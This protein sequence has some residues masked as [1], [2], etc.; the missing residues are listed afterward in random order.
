M[1]VSVESGEGLERKLTIQVP[2][3]TV[4]KEVD[5]RLNSMRS[6][7]KI[8]GFRP[9]KVPLSVVKKQYGPSVIQE[10][11]GEVM[12]NTLRDAV[13]QES[14]NPAGNP[15]IEPTSMEPGKPLEFIATFEVYPEIELVDCATLEVERT[16]AEVADSDVDT[17]ID[18]LLKQRT[19]YDVVDRASKDGDQMTINFDGSVDGEQ[20]EGGQADSVPVVLGSGSMIPGFEEALENKSAGEEFSFDV[21]FPDDYHAE[22]LKGKK[23]TFATKVITVAEPKAP[24]IDEEFAKSFGVEDG[25]IDTLKSDIRGN[26]ERELRNKLSE[27]LKKEVLDKLLEANDVPVP[28]ALID[29]E[30]GNLQKQMMEAGQLQGGMSLPKELFEGEAK[31]RVGLGLVIGEVVKKAE[32]KPEADKVTA[33]IEDIAQTYEDPSEVVNHYNSNPQLKQGIEALVMEEMV[34][35]W[36]VDQAKVSDSAKS[37]HDL[38]NPE[39]QNPA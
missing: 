25:S 35:D 4:D 33:K 27:V 16:T 8:D 32:I 30:A 10:V 29:Q 24:E 36:I 38:M 17:M 26:M 18:T 3:E 39:A 20:F 11:V 14:L 1:Q 28:K 5:S 19:T 22:N 37:F 12:Q 7:V 2:A 23:A 31:R 6:R 21:S 15:S 13:V 9:G 34:V